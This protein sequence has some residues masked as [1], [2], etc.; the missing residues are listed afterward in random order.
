MA[1]PKV[2]G[3]T[4]T[5]YPTTVEVRFD[6]NMLA[7]AELTNPDNYTF[8]QGAFA[9]SVTL[10]DAKT[11]RIVAENLF[12]FNSFIVTVSSNVKNL[13]SES[14]D[15]SNNSATISI[16]R[17]E[18]AAERVAF[19]AH[20]GRLRSGINAL[21]VDE[22]ETNWYVMTET[23]VDIV[24]KVSLTNSAFIL[25]GYGFNTIAIN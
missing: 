8:N 2:V 12:D 14:V 25:D 9:L 17:P 21:K 23:G 22:D 4:N 13:S 3:A 18:A 7:D 11:V 10:I 16:S 20:N 6:Q 5:P 15:P 24:N 19:T 1:M